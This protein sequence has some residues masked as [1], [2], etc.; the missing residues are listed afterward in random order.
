MSNARKAGAWPSWLNRAGGNWVRRAPRPRRP[1]VMVRVGL[2]VAALLATGLPGT[3]QAATLDA[4]LR[5][6]LLS[7]GDL[8]AGWSVAP[9]TSTNVQVTTSSCG[10]ALVAVLDP[11]GVMSALGLAQSPLGP[12]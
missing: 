1:G 10:E 12:T 5:D 8:P 2:V 11:A 9:V 3:S 6:H 7:V 4:T